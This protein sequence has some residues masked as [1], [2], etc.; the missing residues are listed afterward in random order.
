MKE[1]KK[2][3]CAVDLSAHSK[4]VAEYAAML[5][6]GMGA[7]IVVLSVAPSPSA[8]VYFEVSP[9]AVEKFAAAVAAGAEDSLATFV[10]ENFA[11]MDVKS[12]VLS[13]NAADEILRCANTEKV[14][15]IVMG[16]F[17]RKGVDRVLFG[18]VAAKVVKNADMPVLTIRPSDD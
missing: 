5:A 14:D 4:A 1:I 2:I 3:L 10:A 15:L 8:D 7:S 11:G 13:G 16:A 18:S 9:I 17:S 6:K 12:Y